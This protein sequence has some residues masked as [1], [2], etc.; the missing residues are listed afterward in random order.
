MFRS[1]AAQLHLVLI[2]PHRRIV[3]LFRSIVK[4]GR[5]FKRAT[6]SSQIAAKRRAVHDEY[7]ALA[8]TEAE[9]AVNQQIMDVMRQLTARPDKIGA[10][11]LALRGNSE[12]DGAEERRKICFPKT[13]VY[14]YKVPKEWIV[15]IATTVRAP[16]P[17]VA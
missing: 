10:V 11:L 12:A 2:R 6:S 3:A 1:S 5:G 9:H 14:L 15:N 8:Q 13:Y 16:H 17:L 7:E 4:M